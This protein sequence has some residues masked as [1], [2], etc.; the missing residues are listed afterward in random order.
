MSD[1]EDSCS[2]LG[3]TRRRHTSARRRV[4]G[5]GPRS[6][7]PKFVVTKKNALKTKRLVRHPSEDHK[8]SLSEGSA[9]AVEELLR[10]CVENADEMLGRLVENAKTK[11][12]KLVENAKTKAGTAAHNAEELAKDVYNRI[13]NWKAIHFEKLP[14]WMKD[15]EHLH[16]GH[17]PELPSFAECFRSIFRIHTET[18]NIWTHLI[19][20]IAFVIVTIVF[21]VQP[22]CATCKLNIHLS[23]KLI[24]LAF[25]IGALLCLACSTLFHTVACHSE[26]VSQVFS[27]LDYAGIALLIVGSTIPWLY[28]GFY[29]QFYTKLTYIILIAIFGILT[30]I[31]SLWDKF[32]APEWRATRAV[33]FVSLAFLCCAPLVHY[34]IQNGFYTGTVEASLYWMILMGA[35]YITGAVLYATRTPERFLPGKC[36]IWFQSHQIFHVLVIVAAFVHYHGISEMAVYRLTKYGNNC[37]APYDSTVAPAAAVADQLIQT[38]AVVF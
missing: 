6:S 20:F 18:G 19:G 16:F 10:G 26:W 3:T 37:D 35:L 33:T 4:G 22:L 13:T 12:D 34:V 21:F 36:D 17:R 38:S 28:Y 7:T 23:D 1:S 25:F 32:N 15:N 9:G 29:C 30:I 31:L 27:R 11:A 8:R 2:D 24:F 5:G 14:S